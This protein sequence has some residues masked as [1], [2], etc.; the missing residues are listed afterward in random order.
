[1]IKISVSSPPSIATIQIGTNMS[2]DVEIYLFSITVNG[3]GV[4]NISGV[5]PN[6]SGNGGSVET[7]QLGTYDIT[8]SYSTTL[9]EQNI[10][11]VDSNGTGYC[12]NTSS[13]FNSMT[14]YNV[15]INGSV[16]PVLTAGDGTCF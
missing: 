13:G 2:L 15:V 5:N 4:T 3:V 16:N 6:T 14:F 8:L 9:S 1:M 11:L 7:N 12:N 10:S